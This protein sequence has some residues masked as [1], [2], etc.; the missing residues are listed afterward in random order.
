MWNRTIV[1]AVC[2]SLANCNCI[3]RTPPEV[4]KF[5]CLTPTWGEGGGPVRWS[6]ASLTSYTVKEM[7][8]NNFS[9][10]T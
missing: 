7:D 5:L 1:I 2:E 6:A 9:Y 10:G 3:A 8:R 4:A